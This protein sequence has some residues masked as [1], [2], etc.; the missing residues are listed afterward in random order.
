MWRA[1][2]FSNEGKIV[3][4]L[5]DMP[6]NLDNSQAI[7]D[8][9]DDNYQQVTDSA[10]DGIGLSARGIGSK[11]SPMT[12]M[13]IF[14]KIGFWG[15]I[16]VFMHILDMISDI[17]YLIKVPKYNFYYGCGIAFFMCLPIVVTI[18]MVWYLKFKGC[19]QNFMMVVRKF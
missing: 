13:E 18:C 14:K 6:D 10:N 2:W 5:D 19:Y 8:D 17:L 4:N 7:D 3:D 12:T 11:Q 15:F 16:S 9:N 1:S